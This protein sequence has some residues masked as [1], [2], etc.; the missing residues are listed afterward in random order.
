MKVS[1]TKDI[2][3]CDD[4][5]FYKYIRCVGYDCFHPDVPEEE[6]RG[7]DE[8]LAENAKGSFPKWCPYNKAFKQT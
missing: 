8:P 2:Y 7:E 3:S 1:F 6:E 5:P 4:C